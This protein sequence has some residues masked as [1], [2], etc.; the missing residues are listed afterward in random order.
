MQIGRSDPEAVLSYC[1]GGRI[2]Q[3]KKRFR[4]RKQTCRFLARTNDYT[5]RAIIVFCGLRRPIPSCNDE[6]QLDADW[7]I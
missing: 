6:E 5:I 3:S 1:E 2:I 4:S 7:T